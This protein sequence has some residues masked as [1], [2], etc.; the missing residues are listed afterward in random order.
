MRKTCNTSLRLRPRSV[1]GTR[2]KLRNELHRSSGCL[3]RPGGIV[4]ADPAAGIMKGLPLF[5]DEF[6]AVLPRRERELQHAE[7]FPV[8]NLAVRRG[9]TKEIMAASASPRYGFA[10]SVRGVGFTLRVLWCKTFVGM[11]VSCK[12]QVSVG[13]V[14]VAPELLQLGMDCVLFEDTAAEERMMTIR[15]N[16]RVKMF[17]K[18]LFQPSLLGL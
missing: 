16:A 17:R 12:N 4:M 11:F 5:G 15:Q 8:P 13:G 9:E 14:Q 6:P 7:R 18:I 2:R 3:V 10:D 1:T